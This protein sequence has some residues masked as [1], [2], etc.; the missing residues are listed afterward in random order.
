MAKSNHEGESI[1]IVGMSCRFGADA[2]NP[3][4]LWKMVVEGRSAWSGIPSHRFNLASVHHPNPENI[5]TTSVRGGHFMSEDIALFDATFFNLS[6]EMAATMDPQNRMQ[7]ESVYEA[8]EN[9]GIPLSQVA[10]SRTSV[11]TGTFLHDYQDSQMRDPE[12]LPRTLITGNGAAMASN[13]ISHFF[14]LQGPSMTID[15][16][17][18]ASLTSLH[19]ACQSLKTGDA[20]MSIV[21]GSNLMLNPDWFIA[22]D[23]QG[24][25]SPDGK[26][27]SFDHR[28]N[29]YGRG[30]GVATIV[31]KR[32]NDAVDAGD[33]IRAVIRG[34]QLNQD[35]KTE[36]IT[37]PSQEAQEQLI[38]SCYQVAGVDP[39]EI[40][41]FEAHGTGTRTGDPI[42]VGAIASI[43]KDGRSP[44]KPLFIGS[45]KSNLGHTEPAS[46]LASLLKVVM[47]LER[48][49]IPPSINFERPN[50][51][52]SLEKWNLKVPN[53]C[54]EWCPGQD[55]VRRA[56]INNF[57]YGGGN[58]HVIV[59]EWTSP[60]TPDQSRLSNR[61]GH[62]NGNGYHSSNGIAELLVTN[63]YG[64]RHHGL[65]SSVFTLSAN[66][67][68][69]CQVV[70]TNL[71]KYLSDK[72]LSGL[73]EEAEF[74][75]NLAYTLDRRR[76][77]FSYASTFVAASVPELITALENPKHRKPQRS[78]V[79]QPRIG[80]VFTGQGAQWYAMGREL[81][82]TYP[83]YKASL[84]E[85]DGYLQEF[86]SDWSLLEELLRDEKTSRVGQLAIS[87]PLCVALQI[88]LVRLLEHWGI[89][90]AG[91][92]SHSSGEIAAAYA[93][94]A[95]TYRSAMAIGYCR[96]ESAPTAT[97]ATGGM[98]AV[99]VG[100]ATAE[101]LL[102]KVKHGKA[103]VACINS[104]T[105]VTISGDVTAIEEVER[106][107][108]DENLFARRLRVGTA[109]HS[110]FM[111][112]FS[113]PY[114]RQMRQ[115]GVGQETLEM[116]PIRFGSPTT[117]TLIS[118]A[119]DIRNPEHWVAGMLKPV[120]FVDA[121]REMAF[122]SS[123]GKTTIDIVIE[124]GP[125]AALSAPIGDIL[126]IPELKESGISYMPSLVRNSSATSTMQSL[127]GQLK[128]KG[129]RVNLGLVNFPTGTV[130]ARVLHDLPPYP[131]NHEMRHWHE[132]RINRC[133]REREHARHD[134]LGSLIDG[135][136]TN[137]P[138][139]RNFIRASEVPWVR[140]H[141]IQSKMIYPGAGYICMAIE[142]ARQLG[143]GVNK[144]ISGYQFRDI[145][146][147][148]AL[149][150]P[151]GPN[152]IEVQISLRPVSGKAIGLR[153][154]KEFQISSV[155]LENAWIEHCSGF[156]QVVF[157]NTIEE[158]NQLST[159]PKPE[160]LDIL[161]KTL[162]PMD[163]FAALKSTGIGHGPIFQNIQSIQSNER[164]SQ[165]TLAVADVA[166]KM[167]SNH[168]SDHV[169][170][171]TTLDSIIV[172]TYSALPEGVLSQ[173]SAK[174]PK[175]IKTLWVS[176]SINSN[177]DHQFR[178]HSA[179][180]RMNSESF[181]S[182]IVVTDAVEGASASEH[183]VLVLNGL[184]CHSLGA[185]LPRQHNNHKDDICS[186]LRWGL[187]VN[188]TDPHIIKKML[189]SSIEG[190]DA[191]ILMKL[192]RACFH[193]ICGT[194]TSLTLSDVQ[195]LERIHKKFFVW[196]KR[197]VERAALGDLGPG[198][199]GWANDSP[200]DRQR[201]YEDVA[202]SGVDGELACR[203]GLDLIAILKRDI[204]PSHLVRND[205][206]IQNY[207]RN[208][209]RIR[210]TRS[211]VSE[212]VK[213][214][215][216]KFPRANI[217]EIG[218]GDGDM[219]QC[220][221]D[222]LGNSQTS[223]VE[224][225]ACK[226]HFTDTSSA[227]FATAQ[228]KL[229]TWKNIITWDKLDIEQDPVKQ[230]FEVW[231]Y[232]LIIASEVINTSQNQETSLRNIRSLLK[233]GGK[234]L[235]SQNTSKELH[236]ELVFGLLPDEREHR[237][238]SHNM[239]TPYWD[240]LLLDTGFTGVDIELH[241]DSS[242]N[243]HSSSVILSTAQSE[244]KSSIDS[245]VVLVSSI[246][247]PDQAWLKSLQVAMA[248][249][250]GETVPP[251]EHLLSVDAK[252]KLCIFLD[253]IYRPVLAKP[254]P[255]EFAAIKSMVLHSKGL[256]WV[257]R[258][259]AMD[260]A[261]P[262]L[263]L[264]LGFLRSLR[265][266]YCDK[267][268]ISLDLDPRRSD[269]GQQDVSAIAR[270]YRANFGPVPTNKCGPVDLEFAER[271]GAFFI[272]R[273][274]RDSKRNMSIS[275]NS[276]QEIRPQLEHFSQPDRPLRLEIGS[277]GLLETLRFNDHLE[278]IGDIDIDF[279]EIEP[280]AFGLNFRDIMVAMGQLNETR[281]GFEC[282][283]VI[284]RVGDRAASNDYKVGD[285]VFCLMNGQFASRVRT[286]WMT[287]YRIPADM[288]FE[289]AASIPM[290]F[291]TAYISLYDTA[292][293]SK[294]QTV[295]I[296][297]GTGGVGQAAIILAQ[298]VG[299][300]VFAT[301]GT[302]KKRDFISAKYGIPQDHI[303]SSRDTSFA[304]GLMSMTEG[305]GAD[306]V[307]NCLSG[308]LLQESFNCL[309]P[310][311]HFVEI[312][313]FDLEQN[314]YLEMI[315]FAR[316]VSFSSIDLSALIRHK[317]H[318]I[319]RALKNVSK[320]M[321]QADI[322]PVAPIKTFSLADVSKAFRYMQA[323]KH[324]G[325]IV[326]STS[327]KETVP[328]MPRIPSANFRADASY[329]IVGGVGGIGQSIAKWMLSH[330]AKNLILLSRSANTK[331]RTGAI[332]AELQKYPGARIRAV[333]CDITNESDLASAVRICAAEL[334]P[335]R[336]VIQAAMVLKD[337]VLEQ[338]TVEDYSLA[339][340]PKVAGTWNLHRQFGSDLEF[341]IMLSSLTGVLGNSSQSN[342]TAGGA[343]QDALARYRVAHGLPAVAIDLGLVS[344]V[345]YVTKH[346]SIHARLA[347]IGYLPLSERQLLRAI[348]TAIL[349]PAPQVLVGL[350][351]G[352]GPH[353]DEH[354]TSSLAHEP[355]FSALRPR[356]SAISTSIGSTKSDSLAGKLAAAS[357]LDEAS[358]L[359]LEELITNLANIFMITA[360]DI[361]P[362]KPP[363]AYGV[364]SLVA[365]EL[366]NMLVLRAGSEVS[367][368]D[369]MQSPSLAA[370]SNTVALTSA[371]VLLQA[372]KG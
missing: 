20:D 173:E 83:V 113:L 189:M 247:R 342:Y 77:L 298:L 209:L 315:P 242:G 243:A 274:F 227:K 310:F 91:V 195:Q 163:L 313:K 174:V 271:D 55:G 100:E 72:K 148:Q 75:T 330:G 81:I 226:Y 147:R 42:E 89:S 40:Q 12:S 201:L 348:E 35:G 266:E 125:H 231:A 152:G 335:I 41:Y 372:A 166:S 124:I 101:D 25:L 167:P 188:I 255:S 341:F 149:V 142:A 27:Y 223:N 309:A 307:L 103:N 21:G 99:G 305:R 290:V 304:H 275:A 78:C 170:H 131:W 365:V 67:D 285:H 268:F 5:S 241:G 121:F 162:D 24:F 362:S 245:P 34:S 86:G 358:D 192:R 334:P 16:G 94:G 288:A 168:Q 157:Q 224:S 71:T 141:T 63:G 331:G 1:A 185:A 219:A 250:H 47:A 164:Q 367:I 102:K 194:L 262:M 128:C 269:P 10:G 215:M 129:V 206:L 39:R 364:D 180:R 322:R 169:L 135:V 182:D 181:Y 145:D 343:F 73:Q 350:D 249:E 132:P 238:S 106:F 183:P 196:M 301:A 217:L 216:H 248:A 319:H 30:E 130:G 320:L 337:T 286:P 220:V 193:F 158:Q 66:D 306:V 187:D 151:E 354:N 336:G 369:I 222:A 326:L 165:T 327:A 357:S 118:N 44:E 363:A 138:T 190:R 291:A 3:E 351:V 317:P 207:R 289:T 23:S 308:Q 29:G 90:P 107:A 370:L 277:C 230:G 9:A 199:A 264:S 14:D 321:E 279:I 200:E 191:D 15:T 59:E 61:D 252:G 251:I 79:E 22:L 338:M 198:S 276:D 2:T 146:I 123:T 186:V 260:C 347:R 68:R 197:Q 314:S 329:L 109:Y 344:S 160:P 112:P 233:P 328:A 159:I 239:T 54:E 212:L 324:I 150:I 136:Q 95:L 60:A 272:S 51:A 235:F 172:S 13:R 281:M 340:G 218:A 74:L 53:K 244:P 43:F 177:A 283:G 65:R 293:L 237:R 48:K 349:D 203:V 287:A 240:K 17:C 36:T 32:L 228:V 280:K 45:V 114:L 302:K 208:N 204:S 97:A 253:E 232:D 179:I 50:P 6:A 143:E 259:G 332:V 296:H 176:Q 295:L 353:W 11:F 273:L 96:V 311:G 214:Y 85:A 46:G 371:H 213:H 270:I 356:Q 84:L 144:V 323:G 156:V 37:S 202:A 31:L 155:T 93:A 154:W 56:S 105:S 76:T 368:F 318:E 18:S 254:T 38:R 120:L 355:R 299:A 360:D 153:G 294:Q 4:N 246:D 278:G 175:A 205:D 352:P 108:K 70:A 366:R 297:A 234:V 256:L 33:P 292:K 184:H 361:M 115:I 104:P 316:V 282:A 80:F 265:H 263:S 284:T 229:Q 8:F 122:D 171:P 236:V 300:E 116:K 267:S 57:G 211:Q 126:T 111:E 261:D 221:L 346:K 52:L 178:A 92:S 49:I 134:L 210:R 225:L 345:G 88:S 110:H 140:D 69:T 119:A 98:M 333:G 303:F 28:A 7:L 62:A 64:T 257:T 325:K 139:W 359:V 161:A 127:A 82:E 117:G 26:S 87:T 137:A 19:Q 258:G 339:V 133:R 58:A 312:G